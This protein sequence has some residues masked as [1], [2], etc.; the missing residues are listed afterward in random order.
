MH[1]VVPRSAAGS[2]A[3][4]ALSIAPSTAPSIALRVTLSVAPIPA[5]RPTPWLCSCSS[6]LSPASAAERIASPKRLSE[7]RGGGRWWRGLSRDG[8][9]LRFLNG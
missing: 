5:H 3:S 8:L 2:A 1:R 7:V 6:A 9:C 4:I